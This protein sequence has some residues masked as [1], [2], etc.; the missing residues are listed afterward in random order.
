MV[1][2][3]PDKP[4][5]APLLQTPWDSLFKTLI[6]DFKI[7]LAVIRRNT[8][9][10]ILALCDEKTLCQ[11]PGNFIDPVTRTEYRADAVFQMDSTSGK[12][13]VIFLIEHQ[14]TFDPQMN[15][16]MQFYKFGL[17]NACFTEQQIMPL[18]VPIIIYH[19]DKRLEKKQL[20]WINLI[21]PEEFR[22][23]VRE[24]LT[25][26]V[27][28]DDINS[29]T[30]EDIAAHGY[31]AIMEIVLKCKKRVPAEILLK[32]LLPVLLSG[33]YPVKM[34]TDTI[35][36]ICTIHGIPDRQAFLNHVKALR[37]GIYEEK[38]M[39]LYEELKAEGKAEGKAEA[40][41]TAARNFL[42]NGVSD[43]IVMKSTGLS[44]DE[45]DALRNS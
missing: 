28:Y 25:E 44:K 10:A 23:F 15:W 41:R 19:G 16:R 33:D 9:P 3:K 39:S 26:P 8:N 22:E 29:Y 5:P 7:A 18:L 12:G 4:A 38:V 13:R 34:Q 27:M 1:I 45:L 43:D 36:F 32:R 11:K 17:M 40:M 24:S 20:S 6:A 31:P 42:T 21:E 35:D 30:D 37:E 2:P 14:S